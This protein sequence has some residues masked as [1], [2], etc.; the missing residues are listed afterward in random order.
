LHT[1]EFNFFLV[2]VIDQAS[3]AD[4]IDSRNPFLNFTCSRVSHGLDERFSD[5]IALSDMA[6]K[7]GNVARDKRNLRRLLD[8]GWR[9]AVVW[10]CGLGPRNGLLE[11]TIDR[12]ER[13]IRSGSGHRMTFPRVPPNRRDA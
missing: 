1:E 3:F 7:Q 4:R 8:E 13:W 12:L 9:V 6:V 5:D 2:Q 11:K 10:E